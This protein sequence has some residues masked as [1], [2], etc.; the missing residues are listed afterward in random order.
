MKK[1]VQKSEIDNEVEVDD[2]DLDNENNTDT[3]TMMPSKAQVSACNLNL[4]W[5]LCSKY[6]ENMILNLAL[7]WELMV[8]YLAN[9]KKR[10]EIE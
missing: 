5:L 7:F 8:S 6:F 10:V 4:V 1:C 3:P 2:L 9:R